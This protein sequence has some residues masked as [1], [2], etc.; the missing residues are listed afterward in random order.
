MIDPALHELI[1]QTIDSPI[2]LQLVLLFHENPMMQLNVKQASHRI[3]RDIW[4]TGDALRE[5]QEDG[6]LAFVLGDQ[7]CYRYAPLPHLTERINQLVRGFNE[8]IERDLLQRTVRD[9]A[10]DARYRRT[11]KTTS[12]MAFEFQ[13]L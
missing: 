1:E 12:N 8:P 6:I 2:K 5:L 9:I 10:E 11:I 7:A 4:S 13:A 3:Y